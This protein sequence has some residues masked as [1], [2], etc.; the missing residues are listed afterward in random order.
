LELVIKVYLNSTT[1]HNAISTTTEV[2]IPVSNHLVLICFMTSH[3]RC[4]YTEL[5]CKRIL[6][7]L[8]TFRHKISCI[9]SWSSCKLQSV[10]T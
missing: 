5:C 9:L 7:S 1:K 8:S 4:F 10:S 3:V 2:I 6:A